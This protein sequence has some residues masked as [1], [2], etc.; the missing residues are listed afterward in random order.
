MLVRLIA[1]VERADLYE[2]LLIHLELARDEWMMKGKTIDESEDLA[3]KS[4][5]DSGLI[6][7]QIQQAMFPYRKE[8]LLTLSTASVLF[9]ISYYLGQLF[10]SFDALIWWLVPIMTTSTVL[11]LL[12]LNGAIFVNRK[13]F[14]NTFLIIHL[15]LLFLSVG[16]SGFMGAARI[17]LPYFN[18]GLI[19]LNMFIIYQSALSLPEYTDKT[20]KMAK[21]LHLFNITVGLFFIGLSLFI[22][23]GSLWISKINWLTL[24]SI[25]PILI[26]IGLYTAQMI[27]FRKNKRR[28]AY[29][30]TAVQFF[31]F[32]SMFLFILKLFMKEY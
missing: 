12:S 30:L 25:I 11:L 24:V 29:S 17:S 27:L 21:I 23:W 5:G 19:L 9:S 26:W 13:K 1:Q 31:L 6:V 20:L 28:T 7:S 4:F 16:S 14:L 2:E 8:L 18:W 10:G 15:I 3:I 32:I 22:A